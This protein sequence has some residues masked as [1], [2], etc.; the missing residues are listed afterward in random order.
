MFLKQ[1]PKKSKQRVITVIMTPEEALEVWRALVNSTCKTPES[2]RLRT[3]M[4][5]EAN[6]KPLMTPE[7][8]AV[9]MAEAADE[10]YHRENYPNEKPFWVE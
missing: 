10:Q 4:W 1:K 5:Q 6:R 3:L 9:R 8:F 7:E 2:E